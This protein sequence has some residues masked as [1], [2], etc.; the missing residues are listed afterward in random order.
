M[1]KRS[2]SSVSLGL[3]VL[4]FHLTIRSLFVFVI[5]LRGFREINITVCTTHKTVFSI[6]NEEANAES[7][8]E[9]IKAYEE[10]NRTQIV[11]RQSQ[12]ADEERAIQD[13][14][15]AEQREFERRKRDLEENEKDSSKNRRK[16]FWGNGKKFRM[17]YVW[18]KC[19][20][21]RLV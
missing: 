20:G 21:T 10:A 11:I 1:A 3:Y 14:I 17:M 19:K 9:R 15:A 18:P 4:L 5:F 16:F 13:Q 7:C 8:K 12:R 2:E 6:V